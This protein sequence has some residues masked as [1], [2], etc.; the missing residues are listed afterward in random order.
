MGKKTRLAIV[1]ALVAAA[2]AALPLWW[3]LL[4]GPVV[5]PPETDE[6][7]VASISL[8]APAASPFLNTR[9]QARY[10]G[11]QACRECHQDE[12]DSFA[13]SGMSRSMRTVNLDAE[14]PDT[15][16][17]HK[18]SERVLQSTRQDGRLL[19]REEITGALNRGSSVNTT[20]STSSDRV[21]TSPC[22]S[23]KSTAS[24]SN[25]R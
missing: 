11:S 5:E 6:G 23:A 20:S 22:T 18:P 10:V 25:L 14:P 17:E 3:P 15:S 16:I 24:S 12:A 13:L 9:V 1:V 4:L 2:A 19:H 7:H 21:S 8:T